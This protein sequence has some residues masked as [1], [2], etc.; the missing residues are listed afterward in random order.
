[1]GLDVEVDWIGFDSPFSEEPVRR[2]AAADS[3]A[4]ESQIQAVW[5]VH[6]P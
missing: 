1:M 5:I 6:T 3:N 4:A 2:K